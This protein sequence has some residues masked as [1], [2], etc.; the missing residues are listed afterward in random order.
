MAIKISGNTVLNHDGINYSNTNIAA[1]YLSL[2]SNTTGIRNT[3]VGNYSLYLNTTGYRNTAVGFETQ[4][5]DTGGFENTSIGYQSLYNGVNSYDN[6]AIGAITLFNNVYGG[7]NT[8]V[9][10][11]SLYSNTNG[12]NNISVGSSTLY[13]ITTGT[14]NTA[15]GYNAGLGITTGSKNTIIGA[16]VTGLSTTLSNT[17]IIADGDGN[18]RIY[19][20]SSGNMGIGTSSPGTRLHVS[21]GELKA[22]RIDTGSEG[23]QLSF[24]RASDDVTAWYIDLYGS[25]NVPDFRIVDSTIS[26]VR[27]TVNSAG[28]VIVGG[29]TDNGAYNLQCNGTGVWGAGAYVNGSDIRLKYNIKSIDSGL[30]VINSINPVMF[31]YKPEYN[32]D[33]TIQTGFIAQELLESLKD[34]EYV[35]GI[36]QQ[37]NEYLSVAYQNFIPIL[38]KSIQELTKKIEQ[39]E[40]K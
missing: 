5:N 32:K 38:V 27:M 29:T 39:L 14:N 30:D 9:G 37:G 31:Q 28:E 17:V 2:V 36:I 19:I 18:K 15:I 4:K 23:G 13:N 12:Y 8:A 33:Q 40:N 7:D 3:S 22:G 10:A 21:G 1:G 20:D 16:N 25:G 24:G 34:K 35:N 26:T 11:F 6:T